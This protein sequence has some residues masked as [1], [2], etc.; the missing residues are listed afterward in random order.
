MMVEEERADELP[1][2]DARLE[3]DYEME[4]AN[5]DLN[6][7]R[8]VEEDVT[9]DVMMDVSTVICIP[10]PSQ[11]INSPSSQHGRSRQFVL[12][13]NDEQCTH[14]C[15]VHIVHIYGWR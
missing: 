5:P 4:M 6:M 15:P 11:S 7:S 14:L 13:I 10:E 9:G 12:T 3:D 1:K 8:M 2:E